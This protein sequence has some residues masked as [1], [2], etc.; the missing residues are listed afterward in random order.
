MLSGHPSRREVLAGGAVTAFALGCPCHAG[1]VANAATHSVACELADEDFDAIYPSESADATFPH[2]SEPIIP[3]SGDAMFDMALAQTLAKISTAFE[4]LP[5]FAYYD[6]SGNG[7]AYATPRVRLKN[8]DGTVLMGINFQHWLRTLPEAPEVCVAG[9]CAHE[10]GHILQYRHGLLAKV[11]RGGTV[12]RS[13]LQADYFAGYFAGKRKLER[14]DYP[15]AVIAMTQYKAGDMDF[16][17]PRHHGTPAERGAAV[18]AGF[19]AAHVARKNLGD[20]ISDSTA[21]VIGLP[22]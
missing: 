19:E 3:K 18:V 6:D 15:A 22:D 17:N 10:F 13:E 7:N 20:A 21:Y 1:A 9:V 8:A 5:G 14:P 16:Y 12:K 2:G 4:V 11:N